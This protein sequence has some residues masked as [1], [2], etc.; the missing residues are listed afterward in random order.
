MGRMNRGRHVL[1]VL[2]LFRADGGFHACGRCRRVLALLG[3]VGAAAS[4][5]LQSVA[6]CHFVNRVNT[7]KI[8]PKTSFILFAILCPRAVTF[9]AGA[10][11]MC[12][13]PACV[14]HC[15]LLHLP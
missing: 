5:K 10:C 12:D 11:M 15:R 14:S 4:S 3:G 13:A 1:G 8:I 6:L 7:F 2:V 9:L